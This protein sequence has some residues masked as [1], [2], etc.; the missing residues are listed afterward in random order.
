M[1]KH[2]SSIAASGLP[3]VDKAGFYAQLRGGDLIHCSGASGISVPIEKQ[4]GSPFSHVLMAWMPSW[5][6][7][8]LTLEATINRGVHVGLLS[9]Y[10]GAY[11]GDMVLARRPA[12]K[13]ADIIAELNA[14]F[15]L[16]DD[17]YNWK[18]EVTFAAHKLVKMFPVSNPQKELYCSGLQ[19]VM[20]KASPI[21]IVTTG[22]IMAT[23]EQ[24]YTD[25]SV[26]AICATLKPR[27]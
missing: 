11:D 4:T 17:G 10:V 27:P 24:I 7:Q 26:E 2:I 1:A 23:P 12:L 16:L 22:P 3:M 14:G 9:D 19:Q 13:Q 8:W 6:N 18:S 21:P 15:N 5:A 20:T 25:A